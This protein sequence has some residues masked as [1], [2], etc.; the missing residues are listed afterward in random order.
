MEVLEQVELTCSRYQSGGLAVGVHSVLR[1]AKQNPEKYPRLTKLL[2]RRTFRVVAIAL[3]NRV[4][5]V[6]WVLLAR[7]GAYRVP[8]IAAA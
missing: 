8:R 2:A 5:R 4:A 6:P 7:G 3:V 1:R